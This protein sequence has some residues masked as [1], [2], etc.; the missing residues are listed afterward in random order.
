MWSSRRARRSGAAAWRWRGTWRPSSARRT[1]RASGRSSS[2][3][4]RASRASPRRTRRRHRPRHR[5]RR[6][7]ARAD[8]RECAR[9][10][11]AGR[12][13]ADGR[14]NWSGDAPTAPSLRRGI[15]CSAL[16]DLQSRGLAGARGAAQGAARARAALGVRAA[17]QL[18]NLRRYLTDNG[19]NT[20]AR[21]RDGPVRQGEGA[22]LLDRTVRGRGGAGEVEGLVRVK[23]LNY[24]QET[25]PLPF[26]PSSFLRGALCERLQQGVLRPGARDA[27]AAA[28][29]LL[30]RVDVRAVGH[31]LHRRLQVRVSG[32]VEA[33]AAH[34]EAVVVH[35][36]AK[37]RVHIGGRHFWHFGWSTRP[38]MISHAVRT[39][40]AVTG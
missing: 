30:L 35:P 26:H 33:R 7:G 38:P 9:Q 14:L 15:W 2:A 10:R 22:A 19:L 13:R 17:E 32:V 24:S 37:G 27:A 8:G 5:S 12:R 4:G 6:G 20:T 25:L 3:P 34:V 39:L 28:Q 18:D 1:S 36:A 21:L 31:P 11:R 29:R 16:L 23:F 40:P